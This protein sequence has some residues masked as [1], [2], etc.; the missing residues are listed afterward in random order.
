MACGVRTAVGA[1]LADVSRG[2]AS[3][4]SKPGWEAVRV[5]YLGD[6]HH[7]QYLSDS[8]NP[9]GYCPDHGTVP[10]GWECLPRFPLEV[11]RRNPSGCAHEGAGALLDLFVCRCVL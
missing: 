9:W 5:E 4:L 2:E 10:S 6:D 7:Q 8:K 11:L 1:V 3:I